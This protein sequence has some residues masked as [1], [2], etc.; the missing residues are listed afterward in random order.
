MRRNLLER[1][2]HQAPLLPGI[3]G[4]EHTV[5]PESENALLAGHHMVFLGKRGQA[6][7][8]LIRGL[9]ALLDD[10]IPAIA[11]C[12]LHDDPFRPICKACRTR[13]ASEGDA[14]PIVWV[15][16][17]ARYGEKLAT[18]DTSIA[19]LIGEVDPIKVAGGRYLEDEETIYY[20]GMPRG[21]R[22]AARAQP[23]TPPHDSSGP[24][25]DTRRYVSLRS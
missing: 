17:K 8:R 19:D 15:E 18:P 13:L 10:A 24:R 16:R 23:Q 22:Q 25:S 2:A 14:T 21:G 9:T 11:G 7:S 6:K 5:I 1:L 12:A 4:F 20:G 3:I